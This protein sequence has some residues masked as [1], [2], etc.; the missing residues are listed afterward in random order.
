MT[1]E[2]AVK[3]FEEIKAGAQNNL[4]A[5]YARGCEGYYRDKIELADA[6]LQALRPVTREQVEKAWR[7][8]WEFPIFMD[9]DANDPRC[10]CSECGSIETPLARHRFCPNCGAPMT[11]EAV[12]LVLKRLEKLY[13]T[14]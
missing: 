5:K 12:E 7:G 3:A 10:K 9:G 4:G 13:E 11:A 6:A 2:E 1:R 8:E 14:E